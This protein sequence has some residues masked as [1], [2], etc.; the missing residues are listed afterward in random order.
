VLLEV[1]RQ[2]ALI[3]EACHGRRERRDGSF[4]QKLPCSL[5]TYLDQILV[6]RQSG[7]FAKC[8]ND[9]E[10][11]YSG[12]LRKYVQRSLVGFGVGILEHVSHDAH[13]ARLAHDRAA[14]I[15]RTIAHVPLSVAAYQFRDRN[16]RGF[17]SRRLI[18]IRSSVCIA[19]SASVTE[20][21]GGTYRLVER[22]IRPANNW[23][24][25]DDRSKFGRLAIARARGLRVQNG[26]VDRKIDRQVGERVYA[27]A[28]AP[29]VHFARRY[30]DDI[31]L[32]CEALCSAAPERSGSA[33]YQSE[34]VGVVAMPRK[35]L[36]LVSRSQHFNAFAE[37]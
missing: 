23:V 30:H 15:Q 35:D 11:S 4:S 10:G 13:D 8:A 21:I 6:W 7:R 37:S 27:D 26:Q 1:I 24:T 17:F 32:A 18:E 36:R 2:V 28:D 22:L 14:R 25:E 34:R 3:D 31:A 9:V 33:E 16:A 19:R 20:S 29:R 5:D 12:S